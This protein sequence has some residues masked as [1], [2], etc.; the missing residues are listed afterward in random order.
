MWGVPTDHDMFRRINYAQWLWYLYSFVN[1]QDEE[2]TAN[3]DLLEYHAGFMAPEAVDHVRKLREEEKP[4]REGI[5]GTADD[6]AFS[7][8]IGRMFGRS[9]GLGEAEGSEMHDVSGDIA[10]RMA[11]YEKQQQENKYRPRFNYQHWLDF[12]LE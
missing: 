1:D 10:D 9:V 11:D 2:F 8:S 12:D 3:R 5:I 4:E 7:E 6:T